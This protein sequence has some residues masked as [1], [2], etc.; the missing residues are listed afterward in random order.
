MPP[1]PPPPPLLCPTLNAKGHKARWTLG[2]QNTQDT[3]TRGWVWS[4]LSFP[5]V[6]VAPNTTL[7]IPIEHISHSGGY[8]LVSE[9]PKAKR[10]PRV[11]KGRFP[12]VVGS[13]GAMGFP[14]HDQ[15][16]SFA[17]KRQAYSTRTIRHGFRSNVNS[18]VGRGGGIAGWG[19]R[20][21]LRKI[22][23]KLR[24]N[25]GKLRENC[26]KIAMS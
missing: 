25:C 3:R 23:E 12:F 19:G 4:A 8:H 7:H 13:S 1:P 17:H 6:L 20:I 15:R 10:A 9:W 24:E 21:Q 11:P 5:N 26:G 2:L 16:C 18:A 14:E 22:A